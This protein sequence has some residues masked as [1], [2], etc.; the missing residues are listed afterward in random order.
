MKKLAVSLMFITLLSGVTYAQKFALVDMEYIVKSIPATELANDQLSRSSKKWQMEVESLQKEAEALYKT[1]QADLV[2]LTEAQ[3]KTRQEAIVT[4]EKEVQE[5]K[6]KYFGPE[7]ELFKKREALMTPI[8]DLIYNTIK[9]ISEEKGLQVIFDR[10]SSMNIIFASPKIDIS[11]E[12]LSKLGI[13][14]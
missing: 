4:K 8:Q 13:S 2:F 9:E 14:K 12:V 7:G 10:A 3:K 1:Y 11:K 6:N 5:L